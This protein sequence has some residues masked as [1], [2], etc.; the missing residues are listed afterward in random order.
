MIR[1]GQTSYSVKYEFGED[2]NA[3]TLFLIATEQDMLCI[4]ALQGSDFINSKEI[5]STPYI[6]NIS[7]AKQ[8]L[9]RVKSIIEDMLPFTFSEIWW[10]CVPVLG[11]A[12]SLN[13]LI[14]LEYSVSDIAVTCVSNLV[15]TCILVFVLSK[16]F[17]SEKVMFNKG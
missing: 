12:I 5:Y 10:R 9:E 1:Q 6:S 14:K 17:N 2:D 8:M 11:T 13:D 4:S 15:L 16:M 7:K 3:G